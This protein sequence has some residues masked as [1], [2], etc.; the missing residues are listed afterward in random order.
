MRVWR[1][2]TLRLGVSGH[3]EADT[4]IPAKTHY[5]DNEF[6]LMIENFQKFLH[7]AEFDAMLLQILITT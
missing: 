5:S 2:I 4:G 3:F 1:T 6:S 7:V